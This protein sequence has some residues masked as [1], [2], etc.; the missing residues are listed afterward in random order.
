MYVSLLATLSYASALRL[1][2]YELTGAPC[3]NLNTIA[4]VFSDRCTSVTQ[5]N[6]AT[7]STTTFAAALTTCNTAT[8]DDLLSVTLY[9]SDVQPPFLDC[10]DLVVATLTSQI[11]VCTN[12]AALSNFGIGSFILFSDNTTGCNTSSSG[13]GAVNVALSTV[14]GAKCP[15]SANPIPTRYSTVPTVPGNGCSE[16][17]VLNTLPMRATFDN[18][19]D[20]SSLMPLTLYNST[21][22]STAPTSVMSNWRYEQLAIAAA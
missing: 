18:S 15:L 9:K 17:G 19:T 5:N 21:N 13:A 8:P 10:T 2:L 4:R 3:Q 7:S 11:G 12:G 1:E 16:R 14:P 6:S 22:C 20:P